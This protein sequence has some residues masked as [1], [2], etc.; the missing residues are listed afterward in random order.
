MS[1]CQFCESCFN[2]GVDRE[3]ER[4]I[5]LLENNLYEHEPFINLIKEPDQKEETK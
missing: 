4:I 5:V 3:R 1:D 2:E